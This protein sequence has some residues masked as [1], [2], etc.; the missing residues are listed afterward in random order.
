MALRS[1]K[2]ETSCTKFWPRTLPS[3]AFSL[4]KVFI[5]V[6]MRS[7]SHSGVTA[8]DGGS[9]LLSITLALHNANAALITSAY[10]HGRP[11]LCFY[12]NTLPMPQ[13]LHVA[14]T[15]NFRWHLLKSWPPLRLFPAAKHYACVNDAGLLLQVLGVLAPAKLTAQI[16]SLANTLVSRY[17]GK[18]RRLAAEQAP[19]HSPRPSAVG[20]GNNV[21]G[22]SLMRCQ[23]HCNSFGDN[24]GRWFPC[25]VFSF[26]ACRRDDAIFEFFHNSTIPTLCC[27]TG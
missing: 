1:L 10:A 7:T 12:P 3:L 27:R 14:Q 23:A 4:W 6:I 24:L 13:R 17:P 19:L 2:Y 8:R 20:W 18:T 26:L 11:Q 25:P 22:G 15:L 9:R 21:Y 16:V 5:D